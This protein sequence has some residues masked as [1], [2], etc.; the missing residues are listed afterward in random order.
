MIEA[1]LTG[2]APTVTPARVLKNEI[3]RFGSLGF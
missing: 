1:K 2:C 3:G